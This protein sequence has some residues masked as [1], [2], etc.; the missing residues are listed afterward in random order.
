MLIIAAIWLYIIYSTYSVIEPNQFVPSIICGN[1]DN[2]PFNLEMVDDQKQILLIYFTIHC[3]FCQ[4]K[5]KELEKR[6]PEFGN[7]EV[8]MISPEPLDSLIVFNQ[9]L[10]FDLYPNA[11]IYHCP[12]DT[13]QKHFGKLVAPTTFIY[14]KDKKLLKKFI[15]ATRI[16]DML[17]VIQQE[18]I[19]NGDHPMYE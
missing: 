11:A 12:Y 9:Q 13:L 8:V 15:G 6:V 17:N 16:D 4:F 19:N 3:D 5:L 18:M 2:N 14:G 1:I 10:Q 7:T